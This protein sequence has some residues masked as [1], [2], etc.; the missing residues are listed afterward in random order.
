MSK[1]IARGRDKLNGIVGSTIKKD[2]QSQVDKEIN[3]YITS[4]ENTMSLLQLAENLQELGIPPQAVKRVTKNAIKEQISHH[5]KHSL[6][7]KSSMEELTRSFNADCFIERQWQYLPIVLNDIDYLTLSE[8]EKFPIYVE[9]YD[10]SEPLYK[11]KNN[12]NFQNETSFKEKKIQSSNDAQFFINKEENMIFAR[13]TNMHFAPISYRLIKQ[14]KRTLP[15]AEHKNLIYNQ[16]LYNRSFSI[17][18]YILL[19]GDPKKCHGFL[20][21]DSSSF[22]HK[23][24]FLYN[25]PRQQVYGLEAQSPHF[26]CQNEDDG[27]LCMKKTKDSSK[28][29][30]WKTGR[31]NAIDCQHLISY[32]QK[33]DNL[34]FQEVERDFYCN[35]HYNMPFLK[36]KFLHKKVKIR[37]IEKIVEHFVQTRESQEGLLADSLNKIMSKPNF[38]SDKDRSFTKLISALEYLQNIYDERKNTSSLSEL[39]M[40]SN[41]EVEVA[42]EVVNSITSSQNKILEKNYQPKY[43]IDGKFLNNDFEENEL[44]SEFSDTAEKL[45]EDGEDFVKEVNYGKQ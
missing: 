9:R 14:I 15:E 2:K 17:S 33:L 19:D 42:S 40:L 21:Y 39:E 28:R 34:S 43:V 18:F 3:A 10:Y 29:V 11:F 7:I 35:K 37:S 13:V 32:L 30:K 8:Q 44:E 23:N 45:E 5:N 22:P 4:G 16:E 27:L 31:S 20:R 1:K 6:Y 36:M 38:E 41:L 25:D 26:H 12:I 24:I